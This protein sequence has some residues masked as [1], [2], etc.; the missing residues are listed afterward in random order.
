MFADDTSDF[1][2]HNNVKELF[3]T[4]NADVSHLNG[5]FCANKLPLNNDKT[6]YLLFHKAKNKDNFPLVLPDLLID[7]VKIKRENSQKFLGVMVDYNL[8]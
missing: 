1:Y 3:R 8:T 4:I 2:L 5:C 7:D 6:N